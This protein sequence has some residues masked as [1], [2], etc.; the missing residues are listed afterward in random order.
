MI[1]H[2]IHSFYDLIEAARRKHTEDL[3][4]KEDQILSLKS[5][6]L[7]YD[8]GWA[9]EK[10]TYLENALREKNAE[11][12]ELRIRLKT[13]RTLATNP[14]KTTTFARDSPEHDKPQTTGSTN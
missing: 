7:A 11:I 9:D 3:E 5:E 1:D 14:K 10:I 2:T 8:N 12:E 13:I 6:I 4:F